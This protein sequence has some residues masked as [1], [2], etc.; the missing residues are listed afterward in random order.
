METV[1]EGKLERFANAF[2]AFLAIR[3]NLKPDFRIKVVRSIDQ[4]WKAMVP[5]KLRAATE[6]GT[7]FQ[8]IALAFAKSNSEKPSQDEKQLGLSAAGFAAKQAEQLSQFDALLI[9]NFDHP[10]R[11]NGEVYFWNLLI[12]HHVLHIVELLTCLRI[13]HEPPTEHDFQ[14]KEALEHLNRFV[15]WITIDDFI[16]RFVPCK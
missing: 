9:L 10:V 11:I 3:Y 16:D 6:N 8:H 1:V 7:Q 2:F 15:A 12:S 14:A 13:I 5:A 4:N